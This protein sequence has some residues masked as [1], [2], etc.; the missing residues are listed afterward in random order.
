MCIRDRY[1]EDRVAIKNIVKEDNFVEVYINT[2]LE[3][4][5]RR[6][7]KGL[8]KMARKGEIEN[9]TGI[10]S[11]YEAPEHPNI[12]IKTEKRT[13]QQATEMILKHIQPKL[14]I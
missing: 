5:E 3:E 7:V 8:Y 10:S 4:C 1:K 12:E 6:D 14:K 11:P 2:S 9:M 13:E